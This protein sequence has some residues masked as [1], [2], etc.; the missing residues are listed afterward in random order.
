MAPSILSFASVA[1]AF[2]SAVLAQSTAGG[3]AQCGGV[4]WTG[5]TICE[6]GWHCEVLNA[7]YSQCLPGAATTTAPTTTASTTSASSTTTT[8]KITTTPGSTTTSSGTTPTAS[9]T[10]PGSTL[11]SNWLWIRAVEAPNFHKYLQSEVLRT[12]TT[13]VLNDYTTAGQFNIVNGQL[14]QLVN[15]AG[16]LLYLHVTPQVST[17]TKLLT[18]WSKTPDTYG[19]FAFQGDAVTWTTPGVT[20]QN[21]AAWLVC[22]SQHLYVNLGAYAYN[23]PAGCVDETIHYYNGATAVN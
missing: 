10:A 8:S 14:V 11:L 20:R 4:S 15:T 16:D 22:E 12:A 7:Y 21:V 9:G 3:Y 5:A 2:A 1:V 18:T 13:A 23:T 19:T 6:N 17:E